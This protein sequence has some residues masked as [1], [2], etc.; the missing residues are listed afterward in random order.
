MD[1]ALSKLSK[2]NHLITVARHGNLSRAAAE[3]HISQPALSRSISSLETGFGFR[4]FDR[5]KSGMALTPAGEMVVRE[6]E[7]IVRDT[8]DFERQ[9]KLYGLGEGG[10]VYFGVT[11]A[12]SAIV[13]PRL[14]TNMLN[15]KPLVQMIASIRPIDVLMKDLLEGQIEMVLCPRDTVTPSFDIEIQTIGSFTNVLAV[16]SGHPLCERASISATDLT[17]FPLAAVA[18]HPVQAVIRASGSFVCENDYI[19]REV[20]L[21]SDAIWMASSQAVEADVAVG[22]LRVIAAEDFPQMEVNV[23]LIHLKSRPLS[24]LAEQIAKWSKAFFET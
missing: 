18:N 10:R 23:S 3:L 12:I 4:V 5:S 6:A 17:R 7:K 8:R 15:A 24:L 2:L 22:G 16:R 13:L 21:N 19:V 1:I 11:P 14:G 9:V 20:V